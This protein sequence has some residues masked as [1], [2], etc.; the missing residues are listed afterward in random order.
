MKRALLLVAGVFCGPALANLRRRD[1][2]DPAK[3]YPAHNI[4]VPVDHFHNETKY[5]P[6]TNASFNLRYF[7]DASHYKPGG[8]VIVLQSGE[9]D[10]TERLPYLQKGILAQLANATNGI[11]VVL[12]HRYYGTSFP[13]KNLTTKSLRFLTTEQ[14]LA[15]Q[16]YFASHIVFPGLE[17]MNLTAP[18]TPYFTYGGSYAGGFAAF[19]RKLYPHLYFG[20]I[21]SSGVT[22]AIYDYW[23]YYEPVRQ[24]GPSTCIETQTKLIN[25]L[26]NILMENDTA[27]VKQLKTGFGMETLTHNDDFA[28]LASYGI[29]GW[30]SRNWD[31]AV[32]DPSFEYYCGN[33]TSTKVLWPSYKAMASS[34]SS[35]VTA[36]GWGNESKTL[37]T[38]MLN[39]MAWTNDSYGVSSCDGPLN[40][41]YNNH[42]SSAPMYTDK[43]L[44]NYNALSW[45]YQ[46]C[47][48]WGYLQDGSNVPKN[49]LPLI[50]RLLTLDYLTLV[51]RLAFNITSPPDVKV[52]NKY[53]GFN[54]SYPRLA[55]VGGEADPWRPVTPLATLDVPDQLN[56]TSNASE[57][58]ILI[59]GAVHHWEENG[60]FPNE[61][62]AKLP[63]PP[64]AQAQKQL[65]Q[66]VKGWMLE[67]NETQH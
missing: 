51:C 15:D 21:S 14:A 8:P 2:I 5:E 33:L 38:S 22:E 32:N 12:E 7:F 20:A 25:I 65:A 30:Q 9:A 28:N 45:A 34:A 60:L 62:T 50:S 58:V 6:H 55:L 59:A 1:D 40:A 48:E 67:W 13:T 53:G 29:G 42:N 47:T 4:S 35:L 26:D 66:V 24:Y 17:H 10:A 54:I 16:A 11:G 37:T 44:D 36:G 23:Q 27:T 39:F 18:H 31:P 64:V 57:P 52:I 49:K 46:Y 41:C 43:S 3:L 19:M 61:T 63:P 56:R